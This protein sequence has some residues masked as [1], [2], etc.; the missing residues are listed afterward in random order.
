MKLNTSVGILSAGGS[1]P[2]YTFNLLF[3]DGN[4]AKFLRVGD[5]I[6]SSATGDRY[7]ISTWAGYPSDFVSNTQVTATAVDND[8]VPTNDTGFDSLAN[9]PGQLHPFPTVQDEGV[10]GNISIYSGQDF[11][12]TCEYAPTDNV[13]AQKAVVG[14]FIADKN[15][16]AFQ[17]SF[18]DPTNR[19]NDPIRVVEQ[20]AI[21]EPPVGG[22]ASLFTAT[23]N[24]EL[25]NGSEINAL[26]HN[27]LTNRSRYIVDQ[28]PSGG[29]SNG[30][31]Q[32]IPRTITALEASNK[33][34]TISPTPADTDEVAFFLLGGSAQK[35]GVDYEIING[36][37]LSWSG[38]GL[39]GFLGENDMVLIL[40]FSV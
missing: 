6:T 36:D 9:T 13:E 19:F 24:L 7:Q 16:R 5:H 27:A 26:A 15:G 40:Y 35:P 21:G 4:D 2:N 38:L 18:L 20:D 1:S 3:Q 22:I 23:P 11:E 14:D 28:Q 17:I 37:E 30:D 33:K 25:F 34:L 32:L 29:S 31:F 39:D 8:V 12:W 10:V